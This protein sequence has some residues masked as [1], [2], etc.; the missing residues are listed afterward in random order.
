MTESDLL[1]K[2]ESVNNS[3]QVVIGN[4]K[5]LKQLTES[6]SITNHSEIRELVRETVSNLWNIENT[7][8]DILLGHENIQ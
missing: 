4:V 2:L 3:Q 7:V 8:D 6:I 1:S 5:R